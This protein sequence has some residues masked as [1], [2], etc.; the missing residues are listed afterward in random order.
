MQLRICHLYPELMNIYGDRGNVITMVKRCIWRDIAVTV[1]DITLGEAIDPA[2]FD[3]FFIGGG[4]D[5]EQ[6]LV[7]DDLSG[8]KGQAVR[9]A[10]EDGVSL[11]AICGGYQLLGKYFLTY[12]G[13]DLPGISLFDV[14]TVGGDTRFIGNIAVDCEVDGIRAQ[15]VGFENHSGRTRLGPE[16][17]PLGRVIKGYGNNGED[18]TEGCVY[19]SAV[20]SYLHGSLLPKNPRLADWF[21]LRSLRRKYELEELPGLDDAL[22]NAARDAALQFT[23]KE[24]RFR[25]RFGR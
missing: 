1:T 2:D 15:L 10:V 5:R 24:K 6:I 17:R 9:Q 11:L 12:T 4:Q 21:I 8:D 19:K 25:K 20:G 22:E 13:E 3:F 18:G 14:K 7:C 23:M 16:A